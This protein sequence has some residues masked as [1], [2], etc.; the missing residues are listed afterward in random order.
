MVLLIVEGVFGLNKGIYLGFG[1]FSKFIKIYYSIYFY[2]GFLI[3]R[4]IVVF[5]E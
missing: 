4:E 5:I 2:I 1:V 3:I